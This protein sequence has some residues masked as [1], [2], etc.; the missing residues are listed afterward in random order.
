[1][2]RRRDGAVRFGGEGDAA[3]A[4]RSRTWAGTRSRSGATRPHAGR[5]RR[6]RRSGSTSSTPTTSVPPPR[7]RARPTRLQRALRCSAGSWANICG[8]QFHPEKSHGCGVQAA[9]ELL[10]ALAM[11]PPRDS[12][13]CS[14]ADM[15]WSRPRGSATRSTSAIRSMRCG[16][17][18]RRKSTR[19]IV[20]DI[21]ATP[22]GRG[23]GSNW[24]G[25]LS[26]RPTCRWPT[27]VASG[28][29]RMPG[30]FG[31]RRREGGDEHGGGGGCDSRRQRRPAVRQPERGRLGRQ[32][33]QGSVRTV[34]ARRPG[35]RSSI[36]S[37]SRS[38][39]RIWGRARS[40]STP[41]TATAPWMG[42]TWS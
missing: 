42:M 36:P 13:A 41:S 18:T 24:F 39:W 22:E 7:R 1:M 16:S 31:A 19:L 4:S 5:D 28:R 37:P 20:L 2:D 35:P 25:R 11:M 21:D 38:G 17:S 14:S 23:P 30:P 12:P 26:A 33:E 10:G 9:R 32:A 6:N 27:A 3:D 40:S 8:T 29:S 34:H 15:G